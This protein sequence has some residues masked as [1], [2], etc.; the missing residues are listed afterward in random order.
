MWMPKSKLQKQ[1]VLGLVVSLLVWPAPFLVGEI[2]KKNLVDSCNYLFQNMNDEL[3]KAEQDTQT[4]KYFND[5]SS[6]AY[7]FTDQGMAN[8]AG[9]KE[10]FSKIG[11]G[12]RE[13][14]VIFFGALV[15]HN[16]IL[17]NYGT[18][19]PPPT[20]PYKSAP[21]GSKVFGAF[22]EPPAPLLLKFH[23]ECVFFA[24]MNENV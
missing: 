2:T 16:R 11:G 14:V 1:V 18:S 10:C 3:K 13:R 8:G 5:A 19:A 12:F 4:W 23:T 24:D 21:K 20:L 7:Q 9:S 17:N 22:C 15:E 6:F